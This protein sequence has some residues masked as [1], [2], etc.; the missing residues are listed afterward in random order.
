M[1]KREMLEEYRCRAVHQR[2]AESLA[3]PD[4]VDEPALMQRFEHTAN[5][6]AANLLD[7]STTDRLT[8]GD[9]GKRLECRRRESLRTRR[10]LCALDCLGV[11]GAREN[12]PSAGDLL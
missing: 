12:L 9:D 2:P 1:T 10:E 11:F 7:L 5:S 3:A 6:D 8:I 4:D